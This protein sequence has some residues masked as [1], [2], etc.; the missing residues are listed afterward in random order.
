MNE[1]GPENNFYYMSPDMENIFKIS[2]NLLRVKM[3]TLTDFI[4][5]KEAT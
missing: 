1:P 2:Y 5:Q 3:I 4:F